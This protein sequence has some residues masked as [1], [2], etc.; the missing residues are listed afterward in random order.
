VLAAAAAVGVCVAEE[1]GVAN[2]VAER[3]GVRGFQALAI[4]L[5]SLGQ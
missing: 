2:A 5:Q 4:M 3:A 1:G